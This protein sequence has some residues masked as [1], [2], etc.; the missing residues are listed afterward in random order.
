MTQLHEP[1]LIQDERQE[2]DGATEHTLRM[3]NGTELFYR[4][5]LPQTPAKK[6]LFLFHRGH[7]HSGRFSDVVKELDLRDTAIFAWDARG[8]GKSP[9]E[10]GYAPSLGYIVKDIDYFVK[11]VLKLHS[12]PME[13]T[14]VIAHSVGAVT[15]TAWVHDYAPPIRSLVLVTPALRVKLYVPFAMPG[16]RLLQK[17]RG[18]AFVKSYVKAKMLTHDPEQARRYDEDPLIERSIAVNILLGLFDTATRLIADAGAIRVPTLVLSGGADWVVKVKAQRTFY[19]R[20]G[21]TKKRMRHF[22]GMYHDILHEKGRAEV[23]EEIRRFIDSVHESDDRRRPMLDADQFG[24][25]RD[26]YDRL[27]EPLKTLSFK[28]LFFGAQRLS[29]KTLGL[30]SKG[31]RLGWRTGFDSGQT[32]DYVYENQSRGSLLLGKLFDRMYLNNI[33]WCAVRQRKVHVERL[34][35]QTIMQLKQSSKPVHVVDIAAGQGRYV[36]DTLKDLNDAHVT[37]VLRDYQGSNLVAGRKLVKAMGLENVSFELGDAFDE[38]SLAA[39]DPPPTVVIVCGLYELYPDNAYLRRSLRGI[40]QAMKNGGYLIY[41][42]QPW[43]PGVEMIA[44]VLTN[45]EGDPWI[46][47]RRTQ[48]ELDDLVRDAGFEKQTMEI[49]EEGIFTVSVAKI[50]GVS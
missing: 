29:M 9:G 25:T 23:L 41:D 38:R 39:M 33:G 34:L 43:H 18:K 17:I 4:A 7:E 14:S 21:S 12:I 36:L 46:M 1:G 28:G 13:D 48:E 15:V 27:N 32:L 42:G 35:K 22:D 44:R 8:H 5:W 31:I 3:W 2:S 26:E 11:Q 40:A 19:E 6:A 10:R 20:L 37:A 45:R 50:G 24:Y 47:R 30:L 49:D 16:L